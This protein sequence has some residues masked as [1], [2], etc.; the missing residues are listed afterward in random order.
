MKQVLYMSID[1]LRPDALG[2]AQTPNF[3]RLMQRGADTLKAQSVMPSVTLPCH[4]SVFHSVPPERHGTT[5]NTYAPMVRHRADGSP[6]LRRD[7]T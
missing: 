2:V 5:T 1:G 3:S 6:C 7:A 4:T